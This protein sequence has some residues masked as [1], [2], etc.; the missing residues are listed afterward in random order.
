MRG[1][2]DARGQQTPDRVDFPITASIAELSEASRNQPMIVPGY[3][4]AQ[5]LRQPSGMAPALEFQACA[6]R[7]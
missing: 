3:S 6:A 1:L 5:M 2:Q 4:G 7:L